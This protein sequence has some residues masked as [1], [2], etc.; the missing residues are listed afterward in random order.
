[1]PA[2]SVMF[3]TVSTDCNL[4]CA[5]CYSRESLERTRVRRRLDMR[6]LEEFLPAYMS[7]VRDVKMASMSWQGGE[8]TLAGLSFFERVVALQ[9]AYAEPGT[10]ISNAL[11]TNAVLLDEAWGAFLRRYNWLV[12]VSLDG[13]E[14]VHNALRTDRG[15]RGSFAC[16]LRGIDILRCHG[17]DFNILCVLGPHNVGR[18]S[19]VMAFFRR[20]RFT[21]I[22]LIPAMNFQ[23]IQ[24]DRPP[25]FLITPA[26]YGAFLVE[27][28]D[29]WYEAGSP[30]IS[31]RIFDNFLQSYLGVPNDMCVHAGTCD[32]GIVVEWDGSAYPC[33]FYIHPAWK[34][35]NVLDTP[36]TELASGAARR[37]FVGQKVPLPEEC[38]RCEWLRVCKSGCPR[39]RSTTE[40]VPAPDYFCESYKQ[41]FAHAH[42]RLEELKAAIERKQRYLQVVQLGSN[43]G[44][45]AGRNDPCPCGSG[46]KHKGC[47]ASPARSRSYLLGGLS[48][49]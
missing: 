34:L 27:A 20:H 12:G 42:V 22:Q 47:C 41:F 10:L 15:G 25:A 5:Y 39:N 13:P 40:G 11:Q 46:R 9:A 24:P 43:G 7:Y 32:A 36:L 17:V 29:A 44:A 28:F 2:L 16:V 14:E 19:E 49:P 1:M 21:H 48:T 45:M 38:S 18:A 30:T 23:A 26:Q 3:K 6:I 8:P 33:D 4:D 37:A 35:G 31:V